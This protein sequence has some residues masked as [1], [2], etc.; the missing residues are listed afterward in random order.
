METKKS[1]K[2]DLNNW[3]LIFFQI[4]VIIMLLAS[5]S[6][7]EY[8]SYD[9]NLTQREVLNINDEL[10]KDIPITEQLTLPPPPPPSISSIPEIIEV[11]DDEKDIEESII[12]STETDQNQEIEDIIEIEEIEE[13]EE[14]EEVI[15]VPF[16]V[17][18]N[19]P[20]YPGCE[21]ESNN[22]S[23]KLCMS[24]KISALVKKNFKSELA[25]DL[26][27][28]G[29]QRIFV[30][31]KIDEKGKVA[32]VQARAPHPSLEKEAIR[33]VQLL[34]DMIPGKQRGKPVGVLYSLPILFKVEPGI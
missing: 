5:W 33:V 23:R 1:S 21:N 17:I 22:E 13:A 12:E 25:G 27:L 24:D 32:N 8:K 30:Q 11:I 31:F 16:A 20:I 10:I 4:G 18:E 15:V 19:T 3:S 28:E 14:E 9:K 2:Y 6:L 7:I 29:V 34:P 26:G